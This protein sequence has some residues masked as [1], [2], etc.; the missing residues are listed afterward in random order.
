MFK[1]DRKRSFNFRQKKHCIFELYHNWAH[2]VLD[3]FDLAKTML[4]HSLLSFIFTA[5]FSQAIV[6]SSDIQFPNYY[7]ISNQRFSHDIIGLFSNDCPLFSQ[8]QVSV[9][10]SS[11][12]NSNSMGLFLFSICNCGLNLLSC[13]LRLLRF[14]FGFQVQLIESPNVVRAVIL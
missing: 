12:K 9:T 6:S 7:W 3:L 13:L 10:N 14:S 4:F 2:G 11:G 8:Y 5:I 1:I